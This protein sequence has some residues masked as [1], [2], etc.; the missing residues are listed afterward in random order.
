M[1]KKMQALRIDDKAEK[2]CLVR[3]G[4]LIDAIINA[5]RG[6]ANAP[7]SV[8]RKANINNRNKPK[9][10]T[11]S[12]ENIFNGASVSVNPTSSSAN[13]LHH[14][15]QIDTDSNFSNPTEK[16]FFTGTT[17]FKGLTTATQYFIRIRPV[18]KD[19]QVGDW[20][21]LDSI[22]TTGATSTADFDGDSL[23]NTVLSKSF[24]FITSAEDMFCASAGG[25][26]FLKSSDSGAGN[27]SPDATLTELDYRDRRNS[28]VQETVT[29][30]GI[31]ST[32]LDSAPVGDAESIQTVVRYNPIIFFNLMQAATGATFPVS[33]TFDVQISVESGAFASSTF[34]TVWVQF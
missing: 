28:T 16:Q 25:M 24:T 18:T 10:L 29:F 22:T 3:I 2:G 17:N 31:A 34:D 6:T 30:S 33:Y 13:L 21:A 1:S 32:S 12:S 20:A 11:G 27:P 8:S 7:G 23:G 19:G 14:E 5:Q 4:V 15:A 26:Q 9:L